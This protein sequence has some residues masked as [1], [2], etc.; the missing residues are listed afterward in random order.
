MRLDKRCSDSDLKWKTVNIQ[1]LFNL[2]INIIL[3][4]FQVTANNIC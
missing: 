4:L 2:G 1:S 3:K